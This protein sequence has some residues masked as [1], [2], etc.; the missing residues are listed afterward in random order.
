MIETLMAY[1]V[2]QFLVHPLVIW[3]VL[4]VYF[5]IMGVYAQD[6]DVLEREIRQLKDRV[7]ELER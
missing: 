7:E 5:Y 3:A 4:V 6:L 1:S 2:V